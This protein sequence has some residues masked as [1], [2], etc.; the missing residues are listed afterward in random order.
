LVQVDAVHSEEAFP[1]VSTTHSSIN[2]FFCWLLSPDT[3]K[4]NLSSILYSTYRGPLLK[5]WN[6]RAAVWKLVKLCRFNTGRV[7][8]RV[9]EIMA[10]NVAKDIFVKINAQP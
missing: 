9:C 4:A 1:K 5:K 2:E 8:G 7:T 6:L 10:Q 3:G